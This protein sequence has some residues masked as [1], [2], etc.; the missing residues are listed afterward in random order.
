MKNLSD[1]DVGILIGVFAAVLLLLVM[2]LVGWR[3]NR[4]KTKYDE[5]QKIIRG[6]VAQ[7]TLIFGAA[8]MAVAGALSEIFDYHWTSVATQNILILLLTFTYWIIELSIRGAYF[9]QNFSKKRLRTLR[10]LAL[11][12]GIFTL[13][14]LVKM[15]RGNFPL[16][17]NGQLTSNGMI[18]IIYLWFAIVFLFVLWKWHTEQKNQ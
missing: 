17:T 5:R 1:F 12:Y 2:L 9:E 14:N 4:E 3:K 18:F 10:I 6:S 7:H 16:L 15:L 13:G 8:L 11:V